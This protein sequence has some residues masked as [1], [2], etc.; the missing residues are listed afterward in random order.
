MESTINWHDEISCR[1]AFFSMEIGVHK[2]LPSRYRSGDTTF[3]SHSTVISK[4]ES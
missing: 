3:P 1:D 4:C 2:I